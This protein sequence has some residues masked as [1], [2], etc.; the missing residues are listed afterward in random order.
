MKLNLIKNYTRVFGSTLVGLGLLLSIGSCNSAEAQSSGNSNPNG[1][2]I[3]EAHSSDNSNADVPVISGLTLMKTK[4][5]DGTVIKIYENSSNDYN[6]TIDNYVK[7]LENAGFTKIGTTQGG[8]FGE[9]GGR[10]AWGYKGNTYVKVN[11]QVQSD[12][13]SIV[14][15]CT[16]MNGKPENDQC[17]DN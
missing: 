16:S 11:A 1:D 15:V 7:E 12:K 14:Y 5:R 2:L 3:V 9:F 17:N 8:G 4:D 6:A 13:G 10:Q